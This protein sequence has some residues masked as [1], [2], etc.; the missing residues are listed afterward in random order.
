LHSNGITTYPPWL[1]GHEDSLDGPVAPSLVR[2]VT[3]S[4]PPTVPPNA[5]SA[6]TQWLYGSNWIRYAVARD[7]N[8]DVRSYRPESFVARVQMTSALI[9]STNPDLSA[10]L[11]RGGRLIIREN[12][13]TGRRAR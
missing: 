4:A 10:F 7:A 8:L 2:W 11:A 12:A 5:S 1:Y 13:A 3:G 6:A 9:D